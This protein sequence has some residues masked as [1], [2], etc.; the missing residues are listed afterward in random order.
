VTFAVTVETASTITNTALVEAD[1][2]SEEVTVV[3]APAGPLDHIDVSPASVELAVGESQTF[4]AIGYDADDNV[5]PDFDP[6]WSVADPMA[7]TIDATGLF[8]AGTV[9]DVYPAVVVASVGDI[10]GTALVTVTA[11]PLDSIMVEPDEK[12]L[13]PNETQLFTAVGYDEY[14]NML[15]AITV[16][17]EADPMAGTIDATGLFTAGTMADVYPKAVV[18][19]VG[20]ISGTAL[21]TVT[22]GPLDSIMVEPDEKTLAPN[23][24]Q[25][26]TA[27]GYDEYNNVLDAITVTW[28]A[29]PMA[30]SINAT[31]LFTAG[32]TAGV[33][34][35]AVV[36]TADSITGTADVTVEWPEQLF[37][38]I[39]MKNAS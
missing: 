37:L 4:T 28:E 21:V 14:N 39:V 36:A 18:A 13:T 15:D 29:D 1:G 10:S 35:A 23:E 12:T 8:T 2:L 11:G 27:V 25:L 19:S 9:A 22:A 6:S 16:T 5:V 33:Y 38:P 26:F 20:D 31:G 24:T 32:M 30:G 34:P 3:A 17:W 7:G